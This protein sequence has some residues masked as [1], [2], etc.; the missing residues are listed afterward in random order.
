MTEGPY[1][2]MRG[3]VWVGGTDR[4]S[5]NME[6]SLKT[7]G[8]RAEDSRTLAED[9]ERQEQEPDACVFLCPTQGTANLSKQ[10]V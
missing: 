2:K 9:R 6:E 4:L 5:G 8:G 1:G 7:S 3:G 10:P